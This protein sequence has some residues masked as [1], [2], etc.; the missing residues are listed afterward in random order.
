MFSAWPGWSCDSLVLAGEAAEDWFAADLVLS[1]VDRRWSG[2]RL[3]WWQ[4]P[5][6]SVRPGV[7]VVLQ[8]FGQ[9]LAQVVLADD[10]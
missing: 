5:E 1:E 2:A 7:V 8:V 10:E 9:D 3:S 4:L 6:G